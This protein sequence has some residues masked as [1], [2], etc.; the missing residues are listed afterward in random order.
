VHAAFVRVLPTMPTITKSKPNTPSQPVPNGFH[1]VT[2]YIVCDGASD[3]IAFYKKAFG[4]TELMRVPTPDGKLMHAS[5]KIGDSIVMLNDEFPE[6][7]A[8][9]PKA[10]KGTS[11]TLHLFVEDVDK[12]FER[13]VK[14]GATV[15][16]PLQDMF[17]GDRYGCVEDPFGH[18]WSLA[19]HLRDMTGEEI[20]EAAKN[21]GC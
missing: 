9:G 16:M 11:V 14:A 5:I 18:S 3:A 4:A 20:Q 12:A 10:R 21:M 8:I 19:T 6:M 2:P 15:K 13:A 7:G 17:W 1:S